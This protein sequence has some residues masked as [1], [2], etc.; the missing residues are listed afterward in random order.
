MTG[1]INSHVCVILEQLTEN[2]SALRVFAS[3]AHALNLRCLSIE[4]LAETSDASQLMRG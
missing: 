2:R 1:E 3:F 4:R